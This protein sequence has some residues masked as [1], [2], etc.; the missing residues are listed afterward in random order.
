M[1]YNLVNIELLKIFKKWRS[2]LGYLGIGVIVAIV[3]VNLYL[4]GDSYVNHLTR[5]LSENF[6]ISGNLLNGYL[7]AHLILTA[8]FNLFPLSIVL[9]AGEILAGEAT[10]G[11]YRLIITRPVSRLQIL[12]S[13]IIAGAV[14]TFSILLWMFI[15]SCI[16]SLFV[17]GSGELFI[18][19]NGISV[20][21]QDDILWRFAL[22]Y[23]H[24]FLSMMLVFSLSMLF[25]SFVENAIGPII[26]VMSILIV[27][28]IVSQLPFDFTQTIK[29]YIFTNYM[30]DWHTFFSYDIDWNLI[31]KSVLVLGGH[32]I[33]F[34]I[35]TIIIFLRKDIL[36]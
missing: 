15:V 21:A 26:A 24:I 32:S 8:L 23:S 34:I 36:T 35:A 13:K 31:Q 14:Y 18:F 1:L 12:T 17:F 28:V 3:Q 4:H 16:I 6:F 11:T 2:Y 25:S 7:I 33:I 30:S 9:I 22:S 5:G 29:P 10:A 27:M 20:F 19:E